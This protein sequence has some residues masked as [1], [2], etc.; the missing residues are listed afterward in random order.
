MNIKTLFEKVIVGVISSVIVGLLS[1]LIK[2]IFNIQYD[3]TIYWIL[4]A[5]II[6]IIILSFWNQSRNILSRITNYLIQRIELFILILSILLASIIIYLVTY[7]IIA[8]IISIIINIIIVTIVKAFNK[9]NKDVIVRKGQDENKSHI[10]VSPIIELNIPKREI[11]IVNIEQWNTTIEGYKTIPFGPSLVNR[12]ILPNIKFSSYRPLFGKSR[13]PFELNIKGD[14]IN[15]IEVLQ[16]SPNNVSQSKIITPGASK[17]T[18]IY[19]LMLSRNARRIVDNF[20]FNKK[21]IGYIEFNLDNEKKVHLDII[22]GVNIRDWSYKRPDVVQ[23]LTDSQTE[24]VWHDPSNQA[25]IDMYYL[26]MPEIGGNIISAQIFS[27]IEGLNQ[28][29]FRFQIPSIQLLG[30]TYRTMTK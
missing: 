19:L 13:I 8:T 12:N 1:N 30:L 15:G 23:E 26:L 9:I 22:L 29:N 20:E 24:Q 16:S 27:Y 10:M 21:K 11:D 25:T 3:L 4:S 17:V 6:V 18:I 5:L 2:W 7:S 28:S 14:I